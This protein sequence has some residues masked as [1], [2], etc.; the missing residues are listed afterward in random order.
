MANDNRFEIAILL[1]RVR[2]H[3]STQTRCQNNESGE[4]NDTD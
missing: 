4:Q 3:L 1:Q 2:A